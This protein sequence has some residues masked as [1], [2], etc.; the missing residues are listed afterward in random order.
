MTEYRTGTA[1]RI[2]VTSVLGKGGEGTVFNVDGVQN[3]A[4]KIYTDG[5]HL[6]RRDKIS[7]MV[8]NEL[9]K[10]S[11]LVAFPL[12]TL[13]GDRGE[14]AGFTMRKVAGFKPI[15]ELYGPG[16]RKAEFPKADFRFL[17]RT[18]TNVARAVG[19]V[20]QAGCVIGDINHS[21]ILVG[22]QAT[23]TL[24]DADSFQIRLGSSVYRC[25]VGV[26]EYTP[27][28]LQGAALDRIDREPAHDAFGLAVI[29]FQLLFMGRHPFAGRFGGQGDMPIERAIKE[30]RFAYS[31]RRQAETR[32]DPPPFVPTLLDITPDL[33]YAFELAF[34][35]SPSLFRNRPTA[36]DWV[37]VLQRFEAELIPCRINPAHHH[38][39]NAPA[40]PWC[41]LE[42]GQGVSL[43]P[44]AGGPAGATF[45]S[46]FDLTKAMAAIETVVGP[47]AAPDPGPLI[48]LP[49]PMTKSPAAQEIRRSRLLRQV[50][51][52]ALAAACIALMMGGVPIAIL[53]L[54]GAGFMMFGGAGGPQ[55]LRAD[56]SR[57]E[58]QW[59]IALQEWQREAGSG[60]FQRKK[61]ELE[62]VASEYRSLDALEKSRLADLESRRRDIQLQ[63]WLEGHLIA[64]AKIAGIGDTKKATLVSYGIEN[65]FDV[66]REKVLNVPGFG[67]VTTAKLTD[68]RKSI[69]RRFVFNPALATDPKAVQ[70]VKDS[71]ARRRAEIERILVRGPIELEQLRTHALSVR[72]RPTQ[73]LIEAYRAL[74]QAQYD[75]S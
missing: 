5:K 45:R 49:Q 15:H 38:A 55:Q 58:N 33:A 57:A 25:R 56:K 75:L 14:F 44:S 61:G 31:V 16:S 13:F 40:C 23:V 35:S 74:K 60:A 67:T 53:G 41:R 18:A 34:T 73:R 10:Q 11:A 36:A 6:E 20:H 71:T 4:A 8:A 69:E 22:D 19:S 65:A 24:I 26:G 52:L 21:G 48:S 51:G 54:I 64:R 17:A 27:P 47:G 72:T 70:A 29:L 43:F 32:M 12:D 46:N 9:H 39:K 42:T 59:S 3:V 28:E 2:R 1:R 66:N 50:G 68:W 63:R 30:G 7:A 37:R 62:Q